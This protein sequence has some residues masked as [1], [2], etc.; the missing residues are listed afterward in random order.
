[1]KRTLVIT[2]LSAAFIALPVTSEP[3]PAEA[4]TEFWETRYFDSYNP[5]S[6]IRYNSPVY[7]P[8]SALDVSPY[9][10]NPTT[11]LATVDEQPVA[12]QWVDRDFDGTDDAL[13]IV[14][15]YEK[16][17]HKGISVT[18]AKRGTVRQTHLPGTQ[19]ELGVRLGGKPNGDGVFE[20]GHYQSVSA[21]IVPDSHVINDKIFKYEGFGWESSKVAYR[22]YLDER[23]TIDI[24]GKKKPQLVL[25][26][27]GLDDGDY[28]TLADWGMD[29]LKVGSSLG[30]GT[31]ASLVNGKVIKPSEVASMSVDISNG[32]L[33]SSIKL[34]HNG[35]QLGDT[36]LDLETRFTILADSHLT[37]VNAR[38]SKMLDNWVTGIVKHG[39][40]TLQN[41]EPESTWNYIATYGQQSLTEDNL[42]MVV[43]FQHQ[44]LLRTLDAPYSEAIIL[45]AAS[46]TVQYYFAALWQQEPGGVTN[47]QEFEEYL[48]STLE[49]LNQPIIVTSTQRAP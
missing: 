30:I 31:L 13:L 7:I 10:T 19:A 27:V 16:N 9:A 6:T 11:W 21:F 38:S 18:R 14:G 20:G 1:M 40:E 8:R 32:A 44:D 42:G 5:D 12:S 33:S 34:K 26:Q 41:L 2:T 39:V 23:S 35:W 29:I 47:K 22:L 28:H 4:E 17:E 43:F 46:Q 36:N 3:L 49:S 25:E 45:K 15:S 48:N 37:Q 24:F